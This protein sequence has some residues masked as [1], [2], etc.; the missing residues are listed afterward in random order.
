MSVPFEWGALHLFADWKLSG[1]NL[2]YEPLK[3][4]I[5]NPADLPW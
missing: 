3:D 4:F 5:V 1:P 2:L